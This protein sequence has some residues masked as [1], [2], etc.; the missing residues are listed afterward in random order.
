MREGENVGIWALDLAVKMCASIYFPEGKD[1]V[2]DRML[3]W[4]GKH[5]EEQWVLAASC[6][7]KAVASRTGSQKLAPSDR[8]QNGQGIR[9][10]GRVACR[11]P[12]CVIEHVVYVPGPGRRPDAEGKHQQKGENQRGFHQGCTAVGGWRSSG[13]GG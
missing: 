8:V 5:P 13:T 2:A 12:G 1:G 4:V 3:I 9:R 7:E 10:R 11:F 6:L